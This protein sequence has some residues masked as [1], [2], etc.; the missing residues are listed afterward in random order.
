M[1]VHKSQGSEF[2]HAVLIVPEQVSPVL[3]RELLYLPITRA[4]AQFSLVASDLRVI[5][6]AIQQPTERRG[7]LR[8]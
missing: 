4:A 7:G 3:T 5:Y 8:L 6:R 1:T 2:R